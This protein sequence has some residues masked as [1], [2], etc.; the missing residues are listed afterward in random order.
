[1]PPKIHALT[2]SKNQGSSGWVRR[3]R[4]YTRQIQAFSYKAG[5]TVHSGAGHVRA[6][7]DGNEWLPAVYLTKPSTSSVGFGQGKGYTT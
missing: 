1:V 5:R 4:L 3:L 6:K 7:P 2:P